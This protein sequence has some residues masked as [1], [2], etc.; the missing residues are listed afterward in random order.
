MKEHSVNDLNNFIGGWYADDTSFCD[1]IIDHMKRS[2]HVFDGEV[3]IP[4]KGIIVDPSMKISREL[5]LNHSHGMMLKYHAQ[6]R[7]VVDEYIK[8]YPACNRYSAFSDREVTKVQYYPPHGGYFDWHTER[9]TDEFPLCARHLVFMT[10]LNDVTDGGETEFMHQN[11]KVKPE[12][13]LTLIWGADWTF[14]HR[15]IPSPQ[16]KYIVTG[17]LHY[18]SKAI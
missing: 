6:L 5:F 2:P 9:G 3:A 12:R 8:K 11:V 4:N 7:L 18:N 14:T 17:W 16:E 13:G 10:Y 15:G 1:E